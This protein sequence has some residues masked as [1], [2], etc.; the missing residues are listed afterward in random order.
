MSVREYTDATITINGV[1][2]PVGGAVPPRTVSREEIAS[3]IRRALLE[4]A[5]RGVAPDAA[6]LGADLSRFIGRRLGGAT[7]GCFHDGCADA[8][9]EEGG[10]RWC[11]WAT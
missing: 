7:R 11:R 3:A 2:M 10:S 8:H 1:R 4:S 9:D 5:A 6:T